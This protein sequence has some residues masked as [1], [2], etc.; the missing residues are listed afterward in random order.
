MRPTYVGELEAAYGPPSES[1]WGSAVFYEPRAGEPLAALAKR[2]YRTFV[3]EKWKRFGEA[4]WM[5]PWKEA[6]RRPAGAVHDIAAELGALTAA[7]TSMQ[8]DLLLNPSE[9]VEAARRALAGAFD[10]P[11]VAELCAWD[12]G[13]GGAMSGLLLAGRRDN[14][15]TI[16]LV[17]LMD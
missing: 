3:G 1:G 14:G 11:D 6:Y 7:P 9:G 2:T 16:V 5:G 8:V 13:D 10:A 15:E 12:V 17:L 4:A